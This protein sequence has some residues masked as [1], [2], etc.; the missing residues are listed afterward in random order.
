M[1][2]WSRSSGRRLKRRARDGSGGLVAYAHGAAEADAADAPDATDAV[3]A[4]HAADTGCALLTSHTAERGQATIDPHPEHRQGA[5]HHTD[6]GGCCA[7]CDDAC[8]PAGGS[9]PGN[10]GAVNRCGTAGDDR[11]VVRRDAPRDDR[12]VICCGTSGDQRVAPRG[13]AVDDRRTTS[14]ALPEHAERSTSTRSVGI[15]GR[16]SLR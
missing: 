10:D 9:A 1:S 2:W 4:I 15:H 3:D 13:L 7:A 14:T 12:A 11:A 8:A 5:Q 16:Q 6:A